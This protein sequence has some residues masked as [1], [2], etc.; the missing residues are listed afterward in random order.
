[1]TIDQVIE[2]YG[3]ISKTAEAL[4]ISYQAVSQ[5]ADKN[6]VPTGRQFQIQIETKGKLTADKSCAA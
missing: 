1:M 3:G 6:K 2:Y 5:W 4:G